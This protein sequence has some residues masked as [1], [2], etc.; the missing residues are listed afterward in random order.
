MRKALFTS[1]LLF[2][3]WLA[4]AQQ[5]KGNLAKPQRYGIY[6]KPLGLVDP[7]PNLTFGVHAQPINRIAIDQEVG[8]VNPYTSLWAVFLTE[9][10]GPSFIAK[11]RYGVKTKTT[12][13]I[14][15]GEMNNRR[16]QLFVGPQFFYHYEQ[17][18]HKEWFTRYGGSFIQLLPADVIYQ[19]MGGNMVFGGVISGKEKNFFMEFYMGLGYRAQIVSHAKS[20]PADAESQSDAFI[21]APPTEVGTYHHP[22]FTLG[23]KIGLWV[24]KKP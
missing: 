7:K 17:D 14:M 13:K 21:Y 8:F 2:T 12:L 10:R 24:K 5:E 23:L 11:G 15:F 4:F 18:K 16:T 20:R 1:L 6:F 3:A 22:N 9:N 19:I